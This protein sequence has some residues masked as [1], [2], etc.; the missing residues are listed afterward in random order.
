MKSTREKVSYCI[1]LETGRNLKRQFSDMDSGLLKDGFDDGIRDTTP[2]LNQEEIQ[3]IM[4][5]L[6][7]RGT[8]SFDALITTRWYKTTDCTGSSKTTR[9]PFLVQGQ[10]RDEIGDPVF[11]F[12]MKTSSNK[13]HA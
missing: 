1:G 5:E 3:S 2:R 4:Q 11:L 7:Q 13:I 10:D 6:R 8:T 9:Q 12:T